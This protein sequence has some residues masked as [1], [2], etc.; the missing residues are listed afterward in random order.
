MFLKFLLLFTISILLFIDCYAQINEV[1]SGSYRHTTKTSFVRDSNS[2]LL[3]FNEFPS[4][5]NYLESLPADSIFI[6]K[7]PDVRRKSSN[8]MKRTIEENINV[9]ID[10]CWIF[11]IN[12]E[13][14]KDYHII[15]G[16]SADVSTAT[17]LNVEVTGLPPD[18]TIDTEQMKQVRTILLK[19]FP[20]LKANGYT[21][22]MPPVKVRIKGSAI[23]DGDHTAGTIGHKSQKPKTVWEI[24]PVYSI[25][26]LN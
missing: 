17:F 4:I 25:E 13:S 19:M 2:E 18:S 11:D 21:E 6:K 14:D 23:F 12:H 24:H 26:P 8:D 15:V 7:Y 1:F 9:E 20:N 22:I 5:I 16:N 3:P 10:S